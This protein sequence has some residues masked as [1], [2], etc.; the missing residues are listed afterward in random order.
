MRS[1]IRRRPAAGLLA[2]LL[3][4]TALAATPGTAEAQA[5]PTGP[6]RYD[7]ANGC[8]ALRSP[9]TGYV[10]RGAD[11]FEAT[12]ADLGSA[13]PFFLEPTELGVY[14]LYGSAEDFLADDGTGTQMATGP[15]ATSEWT[16]DAHTQGGFTLHEFASGNGLGVD[17]AGQLVQ[18]DPGNSGENRQ[19]LVEAHT[20]CAL[21]PEISPDVEGEP[22]RGSTTTTQVLGYADPHLHHMAFE[23]LGGGAHCGRPWHRYGVAFALVDCPDHAGDG[24]AAV[25][26]NF[27]RNGSPSGT[28]STD[29]WPTFEG[30]PAHD[31]L[32]HEGTYWTWMERAWRAGLRM[33]VQLNVEN[34]ALCE[35]Y[36]IKTRLSCNEMDSVRLQL[37]HIRDLENYTDAQYG[38]PGEG[39]LRIV[40][41][42][43]EAREVMNDGKLAVILGIEISALFDCRLVQGQPLCDEAQID[44]QLQ[45]MLDLGVRQME[46][47]NKF[48]NALSGVAGDGGA[49]GVLVNA[50]Q[51]EQSGRFWDMRTCEIPEGVAE[52]D[53]HEHDRAPTGIPVGQIP[54]QDAIFGAVNDLYGPGAVAP[55][56]GDA[57]LCNEF[58][59]TDLG[60]YATQKLMEA[61]VLIDPDHMSVKARTELIEQVDAAGYEGILSSHSWSTPGAY[62]KILE[63]GGF[64]GAIP[65]GG[66]TG[67]LNDYRD[68][69]GW[70]DERYFFGFG[71]GADNNG[72][73]TQPGPVEGLL[74]E[75]GKPAVTYPFEG[76]GGVIVNQHTSGTRLYDVNTDGVSHYGLYPDWWEALRL[77]EGDQI[78]VDMQNAAEAF[79]QTWERAVGIAGDAC[80]ADIPDLTRAQVE[81]LQPG[82]LWIDVLKAI[83]QPVRRYDQFYDHCVE[84]G[85]IVTLEF[86]ADDRLI[87]F[88]GGGSAPTAPGVDPAGDDL[89]AT[90]G[91]L[92]L[93]ALGIAA[94]G[95]A[96]RRRP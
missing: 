52:E 77:L 38:G 84:G 13:E 43:F 81:A 44:E 63:M 40:T 62:E 42:P 10:V 3:A 48:D 66:T 14:L 92:A 32:T 50:G 20:G 58:G 19:F 45:E 5:G 65:G 79:L 23:F 22:H 70:Q 47:T 35:L 17:E 95:T 28:H 68:A 94:V 9:L 61:Q 89:P 87:G 96:L 26:E 34:G 33:Y 76:L 86:D 90:G 25:L 88:G 24:Q 4:A 31:S 51:F 85:Q 6:D 83:G 36:P 16:I 80:R 2:G 11:A 41:D 49:T 53:F 30:W 69:R 64:I 54:E 74:T 93:A 60:A 55:A 12:G 15:S 73:A 7:L 1:S 18:T 56:Y 29:G 72:F 91:G 8:W 78:R 37:Q 75:A 71:Y 82:T 39:F 46:L 67:F 21:Y 59:L 57:P 27:L